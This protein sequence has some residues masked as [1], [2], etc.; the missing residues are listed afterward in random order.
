MLTDNIILNIV[1]CFALGT[2]AITA[3]AGGLGLLAKHIAKRRGIDTSH[4]KFKVARPF[5]KD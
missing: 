2:V 3:I 4:V 1:I 5:K